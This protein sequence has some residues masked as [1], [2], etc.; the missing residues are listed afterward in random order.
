MDRLGCITQLYYMD[1][2]KGVLFGTLFCVEGIVGGLSASKGYAEEAKSHFTSKSPGVP[3]PHPGVSSC[4]VF[5]DSL[6]SNQF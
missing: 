5:T 4:D 3:C 1:D 6:F 2:E